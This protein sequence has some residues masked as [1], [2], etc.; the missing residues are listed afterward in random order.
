MRRQIAYMNFFGTLLEAQGKMPKAE[1][2][3]RLRADDPV[4]LGTIHFRSG[5]KW[6]NRMFKN[7]LAFK[8]R[9]AEV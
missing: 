3:N 4:W 2:V 6:P 7:G 9:A 8:C 1:L 5:K